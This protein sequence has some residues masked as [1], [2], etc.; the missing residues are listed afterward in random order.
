MIKPAEYFIGICDVC[1]TQWHDEHNGFSAFNDKSYLRDEMNECDWHFGD[2]DEGVSG[3]CYC[4][5]C[6]SRDDED[7]FHLKPINP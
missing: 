4:P 6:W 7:V 3:E 2:G 1:G 5:N